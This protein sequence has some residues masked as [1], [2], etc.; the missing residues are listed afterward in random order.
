[1]PAPSLD[2]G[3]A[4]SL[5]RAARSLRGR[6]PELCEERPI[7]IV[8]HELHTRLLDELRGLLRMVLLDVD[9][10][11]A[12]GNAVR[13]ALFPGVKPLD[14]GLD[15]HRGAFARRA[16]VGEEIEHDDFAREVGEPYL[17]TR[18][19]FWQFE[20]GSVGWLGCVNRF[21][22][23]M[24]CMARHGRAINIAFLDGHAARTP[25]E[26]LWKLRWNNRWVERD[27]NLPP[28]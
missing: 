25:L 16:P 2:S 10:H 1:M 22:L 5:G 12:N 11:D 21:G 24:V 3:V 26:D 14:A 6:A 28:E 20:R 15:L 7:E 8:Q 9:G 18:F 23:R 19:P 13:I 4:E 17:F 27:V